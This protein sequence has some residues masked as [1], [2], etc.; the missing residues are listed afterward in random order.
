[1]N[2][3]VHHFAITFNDLFIV[4][5]LI[6]AGTPAAGT[7]SNPMRTWLRYK[8]HSMR[9][10]KK[11]NRQAFSGEHFALKFHSNCNHLFNAE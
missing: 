8:L 1:M 10:V 5:M 11:D 2:M 3:N 7:I 9:L 6:G 4:D